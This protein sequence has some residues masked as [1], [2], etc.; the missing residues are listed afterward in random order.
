MSALGELCKYR[1]DLSGKEA[2]NA[3]TLETNKQTNK[4]ND[5]KKNLRIKKKED[6]SDVIYELALN[7]AK[8][9]Q[10]YSRLFSKCHHHFMAPK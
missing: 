1:F 2:Y 5:K 9:Q 6:S 4:Q 3:T 7:K 8:Q 10:H